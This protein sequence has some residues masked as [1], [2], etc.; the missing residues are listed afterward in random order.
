MEFSRSM[1]N[2][3]PVRSE[4]VY[5]SHGVGTAED[6]IMHRA[7]WWGGICPGAPA[8]LN[9][10]VGSNLPREFPWGRIP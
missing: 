8:E 6:R 4:W 10:C 1:Q 2:V 7:W 3:D 9:L 5:I